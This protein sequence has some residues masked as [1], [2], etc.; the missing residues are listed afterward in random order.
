MR[1]GAPSEALPALHDDIDISG[2]ELDTAAD[3]AGHFG[4]DQAGAGAEK[5]IIDR[6]AG[7]AVIGDRAAHALDRLLGAVSPTLLTLRVAERVV[8]GDFPDRRLGAVTLPV[9][10]L[11]RGTAYQQVSCFQ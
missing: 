2:V 9:A 4:C 3:A 10:D 5:R 1:R 6:L 8:V 11:A 7:P